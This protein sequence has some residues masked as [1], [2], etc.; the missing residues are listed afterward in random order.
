[1]FIRYSQSSALEKPKG[2][3]EKFSKRN[4]GAL[5]IFYANFIHTE[6]I[7]TNN[8]HIRVCYIAT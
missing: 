5:I 6:T 1:M 4:I 8:K 7:G 3:R 2:E